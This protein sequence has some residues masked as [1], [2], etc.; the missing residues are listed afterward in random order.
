MQV[1]LNALYLQTESNVC[2]FYIVEV[3]ANLF[4]LAVNF[5]TSSSS[6]SHPTA[7]STG[8]EQ[9]V[10]AQ[11]RKYLQATQSSESV[12]KFDLLYANF[13]KTVCIN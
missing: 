7:F 13:Q 4:K 8:D 2:F 12:E 6:S 9:F 11:I 3:S 10:V 1:K 5:L